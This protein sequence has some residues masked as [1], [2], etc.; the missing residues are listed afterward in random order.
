ML[1]WMDVADGCG[2]GEAVLNADGVVVGLRGVT[3]DITD[4]KRAEEALHDREQRL[5]SYFN[6]PT[7]GIA[8]TSP[9]K[10]WLE[11]NVRLCAMLELLH[12]G[13]PGW[14]DLG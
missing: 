13:T 4:R 14:N 3:Q 5:R 7:I 1:G 11:T 9:E 10:G 6:S 2:R 12:G 8:I